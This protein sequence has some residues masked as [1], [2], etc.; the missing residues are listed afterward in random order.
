MNFIEKDTYTIE[1]IQSLIDIQAEENT[2]YEFKDAR[3]IDDKQKAEISKDVSAFANAD[4]GVIIYGLNE[5]RNTHKAVG[6]S[7]VDTLKY[8]KEWLENVIHSNIHRKIDDLRI[9]K[10]DN[11]QNSNESIYVVKIPRSPNAPHMSSDNKFYKRANFKV[12]AMEEYEV[13][14]SY[15]RI[16]HSQLEILNWYLEL[17]PE[18]DDSPRETKLTFRAFVKNI[19]K[20]V[21]NQYKL[22]V[23]F[24]GDYLLD[25]HFENYVPN[26]KAIGTPTGY[27][28]AEPS[29]LPLYPD[30]VIEFD[31]FTITLPSIKQKEI[32]ENTTVSLELYFGKHGKCS[33]KKTRISDLIQYK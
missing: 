23:D 32:F 21:E 15:F 27:R 1:D 3:A 25:L 18:H 29:S 24:E 8:S 30:E 22:N 4:G 6:L 17:R 33:E 11:P 16:Q 26:L 28:L 2:Y 5:D 9:H 10:I 19:G 20:T 13:R 14:D 12:M 31:R 7:F